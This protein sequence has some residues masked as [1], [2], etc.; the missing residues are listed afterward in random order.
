MYKAVIFDMDGVIVDNHH[1]HV[2]AFSE[3]CK[4]KGIPFSEGEFRVK[5]FGKSNHE[6]FS[7]LLHREIS[8]EESAL[9]GDEKE[10]IYRQIY[11]EHITPVSGLIDFLRLLKGNSINIAVGTS[12]GSQNLDFV[13]SNLNIRHFFDA[14][15]DSSYVERGKPN[16][17]I[18]L[19]AAERLGVKP[20]ECLVFEDSVSGIQAAHAAGMDVV[21][22]LTTHKRDELPLVSLYVEDFTDPGIRELMNI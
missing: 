5:Y 13:L 3:F 16:P 11:K 19:K 14:Q 21:A 10:A 20:S 4:L 22:L 12:A 17:D 2:A 1:Y 7:G 6:I 8:K 9:L 15:V 18:F